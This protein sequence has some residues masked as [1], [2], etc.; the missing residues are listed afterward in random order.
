[1]SKNS[2]IYIVLWIL[3]QL[4]IEINCQMTPFK[5]LGRE[6]HTATLINDKLYILS[7]RR[8]DKKQ[9]FYL[10]VSISFNT[11]ELLWHDLTNINIVPS[12]YGAAS[13]NGGANN[14]TLFLYGGTPDIGKMDLV[15][16]FDTE[17]NSWN[18]LKTI[19]EN[20][21]SKKYLTGI[22]NDRKMYLF[23]GYNGIED[24]NDMLILDTINFKWKKGS[25]V[26]APSPREVYG[27]TLLP[28]Q[29]II[30]LG[31]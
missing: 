12:H 19:G 17:T 2:L 4:L 13:V 3:I 20:I 25:L 14:N 28:N 11:Q 7:G 10:D 8:D 23:G 30:Y 22:V 16:T 31:K 6:L 18:V 1:M 5:P 9:F 15:Y 24:I 21:D 29:H 26:G 27:A